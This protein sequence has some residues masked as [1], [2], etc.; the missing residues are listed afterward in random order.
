MSLVQTL[1]PGPIDI[2]GDIHGEYDALLTLLHHLGYD[3]LGEHPDGR[4]LVFVGDFCDRGPDSPAVLSLIRRFVKSNKAM[5]VL[6]NHEVNLLRGDAKDG[7]GWY[8]PQRYERDKIKYA[9][10]EIIS[11]EGKSEVTEFLNDLPIALEREDIRIIHAAWIDEKIEEIRQIQLGNVG[12]AFLEWEE[13]SRSRAAKYFPAMEEEAAAW[14]HDLELF[15]FEPPNFPA[16]AEYAAMIQME[17]PFKVLTAGVEKAGSSPFYSSGR[18]RFAERVQ[19]WNH[20]SD[21]VPIVIGHYWRK[22]GLPVSRRPANLEPD[23]F[24]DYAPDSWHGAKKN[25]FCVDYSIG[26]KFAFRKDGGADKSNCRLAALRWPERTLHFDN[27]DV[28]ATSN[29][30]FCQNT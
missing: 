1:P 22:F 10:F 12:S 15:S 26:G 18:W 11:P 13:I 28:V 16:H 30:E 9:P 27:G 8:F 7:S 5:A 23:L 17:N 24:V 6:G 20:Y 21:N 2:V 4:F 3:G 19:W 25:V 29:F 14:R